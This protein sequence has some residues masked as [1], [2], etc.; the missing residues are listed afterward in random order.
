MITISVSR[1]RRSLRDSWG[2]VHR[3]T[4]RPRK[5]F[6]IACWVFLVVAC[7]KSPAPAPPVPA[8]TFDRQ[9]YRTELVTCE[10]ITYH[11]YGETPDCRRIVEAW[12]R[13]RNRVTAIYPQAREIRMVSVTFYRPKL[14]QVPE[15]PYPLIADALG[16]P[17]GVTYVQ[18]GVMIVY[19]YEEV[20]EH[21]ATHAVVFLL[22]G[23]KVREPARIA[24]DLGGYHETDFRFVPF[25]F[26]LITCHGTPDDPFGEP[27]NRASCVEPFRGPAD[28]RGRIPQL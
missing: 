14:I 20:I 3:A 6:S 9:L 13:G 26:Y 25:Y 12:T 17:R 7:S 21:E 27:G 8:E 16:T 28:W 10:Q 4:E 18:G 1:V 15:R 2:R 22:D 5:Y 19:A 23:L 11:D 24:E